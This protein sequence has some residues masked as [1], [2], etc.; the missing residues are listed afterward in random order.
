MSKDHLQKSKSVIRAFNAMP[1]GTPITTAQCERD[2]NVSRQSVHG[3]TKAGWLESLGH[4]FYIREGDSPTITGTVAALE[5]AGF[6]VHIA[7]KSALDLKGFSH[8]LALGKG[9]IF[10]YGRDV[11]QLPK[12]LAHFFIIELT[13]KK[14]F[15]EYDDPASRLFVRRLEPGNESSP[16]VSDPERALLEMLDNVPAAQ[17]MNEAKEIMEG[18]HSLNPGKLQIL[19]E[20]CVRIKVKRIFWTLCQELGLPVIKDI[21]VN[22]VDFGSDS[23]YFVK[24]LLTTMVIKNPIKG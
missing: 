3:Y 17:T 16:Y 1:P 15:K 8:Y 7:G 19:L 20:Y 13:T 9:K 18:M 2:W 12:W 5:A 21:D 22:K 24:N 6:K 10:L 14:L 11:R 4:G 23:P